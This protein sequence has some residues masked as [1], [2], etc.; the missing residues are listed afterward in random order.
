MGIA[1]LGVV[2]IVMTYLL[3]KPKRRVSNIGIR[4]QKLT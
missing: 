1:S 3:Y 4:L 2:V